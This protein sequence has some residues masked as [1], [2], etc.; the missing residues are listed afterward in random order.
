MNKGLRI[1]AYGLGLG[2]LSLQLVAL[3]LWPLAF[4]L[5]FMRNHMNRAHLFRSFGPDPMSLSF[6]ATRLLGCAWGFPLERRQ[7]RLT[8][9]LLIAEPLMNDAL[10][11]EVFSDY[12]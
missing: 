5:Q 3:G 12:I 2:A 11:I 9:F 4:R 10:T 7:A 8:Y 6:E 1:K